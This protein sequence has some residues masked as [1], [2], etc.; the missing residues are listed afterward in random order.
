MQ[1]FP[2]IESTRLLFVE[3]SADYSQQIFEYASSEEVT[4]YVAWKRHESI[5]DTI[6]FL[7]WSRS[8]SENLYHFDFGLI[9]KEGGEFIGTA[10]TTHY[11]TDEKSIDFGYVLNKKYWNKGFATET[12]RQICEF[13][14][15]KPDIEFLRA[16][17]FAANLPSRRVLE[18]CGFI[19]RGIVK[20][21]SLDATDKRITLQYQLAKSDYLKII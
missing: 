1:N 7:E 19:N 11:Q 5:D 12:A 10:G 14:F 16:Y 13:V 15:Q 2:F 9:T 8:Q 17:V 4:K 21:P 6:N 20:C 18:K 3:L